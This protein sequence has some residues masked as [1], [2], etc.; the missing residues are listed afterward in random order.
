MPG[1]AR[2]V[3]GDI[4]KKPKRAAEKIPY[5][6]GITKSSDATLRTSTKPERYRMKQHIAD[7][8]YQVLVELLS[9]MLFRLADWLG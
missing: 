5:K 7:L 3:E 4:W 8:I 9:Q 6:V 2:A 1:H